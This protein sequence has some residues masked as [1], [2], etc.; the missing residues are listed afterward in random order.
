MYNVK[1]KQVFL[2]SIYRH[3][4]ESRNKYHLLP[5]KPEVS[6]FWEKKYL[7][8]KNTSLPCKDGFRHNAL[9]PNNTWDMT[10]TNIDYLFSHK[11]GK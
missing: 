10:W 2:N 1:P 8:V 5:H 4:A 3:K 7:I 6:K 11:I 9:V